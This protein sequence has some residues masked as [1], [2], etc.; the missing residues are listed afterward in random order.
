MTIE[1][2][3]NNNYNYEFVGIIEFDSP[4]PLIWVQQN[5]SFRTD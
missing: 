1:P 3:N 2:N 4:H 5:I